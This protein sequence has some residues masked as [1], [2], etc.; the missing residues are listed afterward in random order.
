MPRF[1]VIVTVVVWTSLF[2]FSLM[3]EGKRRFVELFETIARK[4]E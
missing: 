2:F 1:H 4:Q 3:F